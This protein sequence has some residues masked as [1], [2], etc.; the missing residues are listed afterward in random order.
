[1]DQDPRLK[2]LESRAV[3]YDEAAG[4]AHD[5]VVIKGFRD[6]AAELRDHAKWIAVDTGYDLPRQVLRELGLI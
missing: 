2:I 1:M 6:A 5:A 3:S 4:R